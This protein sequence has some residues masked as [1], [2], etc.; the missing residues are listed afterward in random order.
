MTPETAHVMA[1]KKPQKKSSGQVLTVTNNWTMVQ[2]K[3]GAACTHCGSV[4]KRGMMWVEGDVRACRS[5]AGRHTR[6]AIAA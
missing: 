1:K 5:C 2:S 3:S 6:R 4:Q